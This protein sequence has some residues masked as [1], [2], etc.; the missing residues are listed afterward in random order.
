MHNRLRQYYYTLIGMPGL[1]RMTAKLAA[2][3]S[4]ALRARVES[5]ESQFATTRVELNDALA[6]DPE[7]AQRCTSF[8]II[9]NI[10]NRRTF[11]EKALESA[12]RQKY[13]AFEIIW[14]NGPSTDGTDTLL[15]VW[16][17]RIK[18]CACPE[19][20][21]SRSR[22]IGIA[23]PG[24]ESI[25]FMDDDAT[26]PPDWFM[27]LARGY[28]DA[29]VAAVGGC[30]RDHKGITW[31]ARA[32]VADRYGDVRQYPTVAADVLAEGAVEM[33]GMQKYLSPLGVNVSFRR[34]DLVEIAGF[35]ENYTYHL[36]E[37]DVLLRLVDD[38]KRIRNRETAEVTHKFA[39]SDV[40]QADRTSRSIYHQARGKTYFILRHGAPV[41]GHK[42]VDNR[43]SA[44]LTWLASLAQI[45]FR[46]GRLGRADV[47]RLQ[48]E[49][50]D[51]RKDG[52]ILEALGPKQA[53]FA[54]YRPSRGN[55][56]PYVPGSFSQAAT[57]PLL[58]QPV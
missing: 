56:S 55:A 11:L 52:K 19:R 21:L 20:N 8:S 25:A 28:A 23:A 31:Q 37:T 14:V 16:K 3:S 35:D 13:P 48:L 5:P 34:T 30:V 36:D 47:E 4:H 24:G 39:A 27:E 45:A 54:E 43:I 51:G 2:H 40:R 57:T 18:V 42:A 29:T 22:N 33:W 58:A 49:L 6:R 12:W 44:Y 10:R 41:F 9:T 1:G 32:N 50:A 53:H 15:D 26:A 7:Y 38:D 46:Q 17:D